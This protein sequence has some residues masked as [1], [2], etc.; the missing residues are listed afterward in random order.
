MQTNRS[1]KQNKNPE[2]D[3]C[4]EITDIFTR[5]KRQFIR[6]R[7]V[8]LTSDSGTAGYPYGKKKPGPL[9]YTTYQRQLEMGHRPKY[10]T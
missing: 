6:E 7:T 9:A 10:K 8:F 1:M 4:I 5:V 2:T 3:S